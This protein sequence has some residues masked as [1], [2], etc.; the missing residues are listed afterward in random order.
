MG[1]AHKPVET[2]PPARAARVIVALLAGLIASI[3]PIG[4][5][6][7]LHGHGVD[8]NQIYA[9]AR[10]LITGTDPYTSIGPG[11]AFDWP[12]PLLYPLP[13]LLVTTPLAL[14]PLTAAQGIF[15]GVSTAALAYLLS[16]DGWWRL[17]V[18]LSPSF[19]VAAMF[20]QWTP[21]ICAAVLAPWLA[22]VV[23]VKPSVGFVP[24]VTTTK[25][26][27][28]IVATIVG[29]ALL[30]ISFCI[31]PHW[32]TNWSSQLNGGPQLSFVGTPLGWLLLLAALR[33]R[34]RDARMLLALAIVPHTI[35][36][37]ET[38][39]LLL[40]PRTFRD[41]LVF[42]ILSW[43]VYAFQRANLPAL[44][45]PAATAALCRTMR[46]P[47]LILMYLPALALVLSQPN[48]EEFAGDKIKCDREDAKTRR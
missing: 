17:T 34:Q 28:A 38:L 19:F 46:L 37:S 43:L 16:A 25:R 12:W 31:Q 47:I 1:Q 40:I 2:K 41:V 32:F 33:W 30:A 24:I 44:P 3:F 26:R 8:F 6:Y 35:T 27:D 48:R 22:W 29:A 23:L 5:A 15:I 14:L 21:L 4:R 39:Y 11:R 18:L 13:A 20:A 45:E 36:V 10:F 42:C 9:G 7:V